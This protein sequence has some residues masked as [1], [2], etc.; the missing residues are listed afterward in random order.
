MLIILRGYV[1]LI[2]TFKL[3]ELLLLELQLSVINLEKES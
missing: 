1:A 3:A 2:K